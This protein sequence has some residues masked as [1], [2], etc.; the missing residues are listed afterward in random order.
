M[1]KTR[2]H[3]E[4]RDVMKDDFGWEVPTELVPLPTRGLIYDPESNL[5]NREALKIKAMTAREED[6]LSSQALLKEG[7]VIDHLI[8]S[9]ITDQGIDPADMM[10]GDRN[11]L[12]VAIL[13]T[14][15]GPEYNV[16]AN[17]QKCAERNKVK[18]AVTVKAADV[19]G[20][21]NS[22]CFLQARPASWLAVV[23]HVNNNPCKHR[24]VSCKTE[25]SARAS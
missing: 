14:G 10:M 2:D 21:F 17:C 19:Q 25:V 11:A 6:I 3:V 12:M 9:C 5:Y 8:K 22:S 24:L 13:I 18:L 1:A 20:S 16:E 7:T 23:I 15:Y 4:N